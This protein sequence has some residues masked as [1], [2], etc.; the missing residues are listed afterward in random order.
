MGIHFIQPSV[1]TKCGFI[2]VKRSYK[3]QL[4]NNRENFEVNELRLRIT[5]CQR[6]R[7]DNRP[8]KFQCKPTLIVCAVLKNGAPPNSQ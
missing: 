4:A 2:P 5:W 1:I 8:V 6:V 7:Y 3:R